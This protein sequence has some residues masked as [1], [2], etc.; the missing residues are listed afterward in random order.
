MSVNNEDG[1]QKD[2]VALFLSLVLIVYHI[3]EQ[4]GDF[5]GHYKRL[6]SIGSA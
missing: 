2:C 1:G 4:G 6:R 5:T 3:H